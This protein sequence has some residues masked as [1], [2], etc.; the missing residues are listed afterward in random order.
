MRLWYATHTL[1]KSVL[2]QEQTVADVYFWKQNL[3]FTKAVLGFNSDHTANGRNQRWTDGGLNPTENC[4]TALATRIEW[5]CNETQKNIY[6]L[7]WFVFWYVL[8]ILFLF[9]M[10]WWCNKLSYCVVFCHRFWIENL[11]EA[12]NPCRNSETDDTAFS[13]N[14]RVFCWCFFPISFNLISTFIQIWDFRSGFRIS[15]IL[16][17]ATTALI[18]LV[19]AASVTTYLLIKCV[20]IRG[21]IKTNRGCC[22]CSQTFSYR[23]LCLVSS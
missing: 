12:K 10:V 23:L 2:F 21:K 15:F 22:C 9:A 4:Q 8:K 18:F 1:Q 16:K 6:S 17:P 14:T 7:K 11:P 3:V 19:H 5:N 13:L 20:P